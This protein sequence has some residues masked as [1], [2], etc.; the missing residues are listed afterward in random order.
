MDAPPRMNGSGFTAKNYIN[1]VAQPR[2][3]FVFRPETRKVARA[4]QQFYP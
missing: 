3:G 2:D 1:Q 4:K